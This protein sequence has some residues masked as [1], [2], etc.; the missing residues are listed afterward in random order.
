MSYGKG[1]SPEAWLMILSYASSNCSIRLF[2]L[3]SLPDCSSLAR[4][5]SKNI[6]KGTIYIIWQGN[7]SFIELSNTGKLRTLSGICPFGR[8]FAF[9]RLISF[10][11][12]ISYPHFSRTRWSCYTTNK[13]CFRFS[14]AQQRSTFRR[15][16]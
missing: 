8:Y 6:E 4:M 12:V 9:M 13:T 10:A 2:L 16:S 11:S 3:F 7:Q 5:G 15:A 1:S 14:H